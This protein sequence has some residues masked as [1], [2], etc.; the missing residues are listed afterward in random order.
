[1]GDVTKSI[2]WLWGHEIEG[3]LSMYMCYCL[4]D[5]H[6][7]TVIKTS[8]TWASIGLQV[9]GYTN[10]VYTNLFWAGQIPYFCLNVLVMG[11]FDRQLNNHTQKEIVRKLKWKRHEENQR[12]SYMH[13]MTFNAYL[14]TGMFQVLANVMG[15]FCFE[16]L[17]LLNPLT[18]YS[19]LHLFSLYHITPESNINAMR[20]KH[21]ITQCWG[22]W[23]VLNKFSCQYNKNCMKDSME[24]IQTDFKWK[25]I[26][27]DWTGL[28][29][30]PEVGVR[31]GRGEL[32][33]I[34]L[35]WYN[36]EDNK[37]STEAVRAIWLKQKFTCFLYKG[38]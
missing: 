30:H 12:K 5:S 4:E 15:T 7:K 37:G 38:I 35:Y 14:H 26:T 17:G 16:M 3:S 10:W 23:L 31:E 36:W 1:M 11:L 32:L 13:S 25:E 29:S 33:P 8:L 6:Q 22:S 34:I 19:D 24:K 9:L 27:L 18:S 2:T 21:M 20:R 28:P